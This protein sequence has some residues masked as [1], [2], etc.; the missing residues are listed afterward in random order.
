[1]TD[2]I[3]KIIGLLFMGRTMAHKAHL[4]SPSF[5]KHMA[6]NEFYDSV[7]ALA[8]RLA[9]SAQGKY[10]LLD[11]PVIEEKGDI[12]DP[13]NMLETHLNMLNALGKTIDDRFLQNIFDEI[14]ELFYAKLYKLRYLS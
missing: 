9:E 6:L 13:V 4:R 10:G 8:D 11:I 5:A 3:D 1:M 2:K 14:V 12:L 7:I